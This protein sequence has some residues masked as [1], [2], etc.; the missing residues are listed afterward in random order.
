[1]RGIQ[2]FQGPPV[3]GDGQH[4]ELR[5]LDRGVCGF[6]SRCLSK[7][8]LL[9]PPSD[10]LNQNFLSGTIHTNDTLQVFDTFIKVKKKSPV[11]AL[12]GHLSGH[13]PFQVALY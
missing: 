13:E 11:R 3:L 8:T 5:H 7:C 6:S 2:P 4:T 10:A 12:F 1:M 9:G